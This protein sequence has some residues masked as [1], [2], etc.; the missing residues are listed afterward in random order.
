MYIYISI[1]KLMTVFLN[2]HTKII[3]HN[4]HCIMFVLV[5]TMFQKEYF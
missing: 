4:F 3:R 2:V 5:Q 1:Q